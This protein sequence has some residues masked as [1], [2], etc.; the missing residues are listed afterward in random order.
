MA[1]DPKKWTIKTQEAVAAAIDQARS[2]SNPELTPDHLMAALARQDDTLT[3]AVL[4]KLG[5]APLMVRNKADEAVAKLPKA[6]GGDEPRMNRELNNV[7]EN[8]DTYRKDLKDDYLSVEHL[9]LAMNARLGVGS[10]EL[11][12][13]L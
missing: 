10:E 2:L 7:F 4:A 9:L 3:P 13:A 1:I 12:Q 6:Y 11:L 5:L 8:A